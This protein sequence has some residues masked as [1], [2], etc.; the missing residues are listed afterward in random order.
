MNFLPR[1]AFFRSLITLEMKDGGSSCNMAVFVAPLL[2]GILESGVPVTRF[3]FM[4]SHNC[5]SLPE[6]FIGHEI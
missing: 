6:M 4:K 3:F 5:P 2:G 1:I